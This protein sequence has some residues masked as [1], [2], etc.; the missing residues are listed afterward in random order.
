M[1]EVYCIS[2]LHRLSFYSHDCGRKDISEDTESFS[3][4]ILV[5]KIVGNAELFRIATLYDGDVFQIG[6]FHKSG[7]INK[8]GRSRQGNELQAGTFI[9]SQIIKESE[10]DR[11]N[12]VLQFIA[13][14]E[15]IA[16]DMG[17]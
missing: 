4:L 2:S 7:F 11:Q 12:D 8:M 10:G 5:G 1:P 6:A 9:E 13:E 16:S 14:K 3:S 15:S 17:N